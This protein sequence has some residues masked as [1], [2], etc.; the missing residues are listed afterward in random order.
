MSQPSPQPLELFNE[1]WLTTVFI[2]YSPEEMLALEA[3]LLE[4]IPSSVFARAIQRFD[5][6]QR[7]DILR[8]VSEDKAVKILSEMESESSAKTL[9][10]M[11]EARAVRILSDFDPDDAADIVDE[12]GDRDRDRLMGGLEPEQ[13]QEIRELLQYDPKSAGGLMTNQVA[14]V[15]KNESAD[16]AIQHLRRQREE[17]ET[18]YY[19]YV[20]DAEGVLIGVVS[21]RELL[22]AHVGSPV[23]QIMQKHL[24]GVCLPDD[25]RE[26]VA[27]RLSEHN[28]IAVPVVHPQ[29]RRLLGIVTH[30][31]VIDA[32]NEAATEDLQ[33]LVG[34]GGDESIH[35]PLF[36]SIRKRSPWLLVNLFTACA[37]AAIV[38]FFQDQIQ[39]LTLLA[40]FMPIIG[41]LAGN[42][43][44]QTL[45]VSI[46]SLAMDEI[47]PGD[48]LRICWREILKG[49]INGAFIGLISGLL[50]LAL[51]RDI[52]VAAV[53]FA[54]MILSMSLS[55]FFGA[56]IPLTLKRLKLDPA[57][58]AAIFLTALTDVAGFFIFLQLG[59]WALL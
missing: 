58:S 23:E 36:Y 48:A 20:V 51:T 26:L 45:A 37:A 19:L 39:Q 28:L 49:L 21:M 59:A 32:V 6:A 44:S 24:H 18:I 14:T 55:G 15:D 30:D 38:Y 8:K 2:H 43:G 12:L 4:S 11:R 52:S 47:R 5:T 53:L 25:D 3:P 7:R 29:T 10:V 9:S 41:S 22:L 35:A 16:E 42:T 54:A 33:I 31:D 50:G 57:Q 13:A 40:V 56:F 46:R 27:R 34:A 1:S 17:F